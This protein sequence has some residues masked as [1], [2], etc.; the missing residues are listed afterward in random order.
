M[1]KYK[2]N[3]HIN[4]CKIYNELAISMHLEYLLHG[5]PTSNSELYAANCS[6]NTCIF[7]IFEFLIINYLCAFKFN[8]WLTKS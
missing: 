6:P 7:P 1:E 3:L 2:W 8:E 4:W 5:I